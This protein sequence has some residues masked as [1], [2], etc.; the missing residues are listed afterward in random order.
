[1]TE[2]ETKRA[3][4]DHLWQAIDLM[5]ATLVKPDPRIWDVLL[6]YRPKDHVDGEL[7]G[8]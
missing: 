3:I 7:I 6:V 1:M 8:D 5:A 2:G 4:E